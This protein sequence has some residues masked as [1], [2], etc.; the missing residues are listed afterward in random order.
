MN[1]FV[2]GHFFIE[3]EGKT[4]GYASLDLCLNKD[5]FKHNQEEIRN[6]QKK[7]EAS[8]TTEGSERAFIFLNWW[9]GK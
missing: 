8:E 5:L 4:L 2:R 9:R 1:D 3:V 6:D 7:L